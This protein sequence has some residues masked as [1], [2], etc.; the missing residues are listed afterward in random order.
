M[1]RWLAVDL[2]VALLAGCS[3]LPGPAG[4]GPGASTRSTNGAADPQILSDVVDW[5][6]PAPGDSMLRSMR[7]SR[8]I[9]S[10]QAVDCGGKPFADLDYTGEREDQ[11]LYPD[12]A[13]IRSKGLTESGP[14]PEGTKVGQD[15]PC[16]YQSLPRWQQAYNL[17]FAWEDGPVRTA[18]N[19]DALRPVVTST[20]ECLAAKTGWSL[21]GPGG[22][23]N[24]FFI[25]LDNH[26]V[27][28]ANTSDQAATQVTMKYS[29]IYADCAGSYA[30]QL[31]KALL[32]K[33][34]AEVE[35]N[36]E[37]LVTMAQD[38]ARAGYV[39]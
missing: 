3:A 21:T 15:K 31:R 26:V 1:G 17:Q 29:A 34:P 30:D 10:I 14:A 39:P 35:R 12:V 19:S 18:V 33:R 13:L 38:L 27:T 37:L 28:A 22:R 36:R 11:S 8:A 2:L 5:A 9:D 4:Q 24:Q 25:E 7:L 23:L 6:F 20:G 32:S 16:R